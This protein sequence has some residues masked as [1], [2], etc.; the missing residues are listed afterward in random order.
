MSFILKDNLNLQDI[1]VYL[2]LLNREIIT[3]KFRD[4]VNFK[5]S[6]TKFLTKFST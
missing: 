3:Q 1:F 5:P 6:A 4:Y 2:A